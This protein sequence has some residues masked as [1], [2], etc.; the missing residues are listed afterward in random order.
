[1]N[2]KYIS[3]TINVL[4]ILAIYYILEQKILMDVKK[5]LIGFLVVIVAITNYTDGFNRTK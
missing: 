5:M 2:W 3:F 1:M 4:S